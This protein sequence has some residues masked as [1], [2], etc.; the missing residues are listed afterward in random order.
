MLQCS[1]GETAMK[2]AAKP[3]RA[4]APAR[5]YSPVSLFS[6]WVRQGTESYFDAQRILLDLAM[7]QND[8]ALNTLRG[9]FAAQPSPAVAITDLAS[10]GVSNFIAARAILLNLAKQQNDLV[11]DAAKDG[12]LSELARQS[13]AAF[14]GAQKKLLDTAAGQLD[15]NLQTARR[16]MDAF[17]PMP[18]QEMA[19][20]TRQGV[21]SF[22]AAQQ[23]LLDVVTKPWRTTTEPHQN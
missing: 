4:E 22:V 18:A 8:V 19:E 23:A 15:V 11:L 1:I 9:R 20:L 14:I 10:Q 7:S 12:Q 13:T 2:P 17:A 5:D 6:E 21:E 16:T 3:E